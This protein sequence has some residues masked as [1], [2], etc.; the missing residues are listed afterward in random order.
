MPG[1]LASSRL[2]VATGQSSFTAAHSPWVNFSLCPRLSLR[3][4]WVMSDQSLFIEHDEPQGAFNERLIFN[5]V[6]CSQATAG[7]ESADV[8]TIIATS[9]RRNPVLGITGIL[10]F[11]G[12]VFFQWIEGPKAEVMGLA[13]R[14]EADPRHE[15]MTILSTD[16]EVRER[17]F[18]TWDMELVGAENIQE[19]LLDAIETAQDQKSVDALQRLLDKLQTPDE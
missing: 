1:C 18:P 7:V 6:Y 3:L 11:G 17:I 16:E 8:D 19:V 2:L 4:L 15:M 10:V 5:L 13:S 14:I 12:G 9:R